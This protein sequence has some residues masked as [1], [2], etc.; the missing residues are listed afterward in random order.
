MNRTCSWHS[1]ASS[2]AIAAAML[3]AASCCSTGT[4]SSSMRCCSWHASAR[5]LAVAAALDRAQIPHPGRYTLALLFRR[6]QTCRAVGIVKNHGWYC[7][8]CGAEAPAT[9]NVYD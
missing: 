6:C 5:W 4:A 3:A 8:L 9:W 7:S 2:C 1:A